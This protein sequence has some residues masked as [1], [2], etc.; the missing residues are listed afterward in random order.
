MPNTIYFENQKIDKI[1]R[2]GFYY[3]LAFI[4]IILW[5]CFIPT[6]NFFIKDVMGA[7]NYQE[8]VHLV[9]LLLG[10]YVCF[11]FT[12]TINSVFIAN[13]R[14]ELF[15]LETLVVKLTVYPIYFILY[16]LNIWIPTLDSIS[17]MFGIGLVV[18]FVFSSVIGIIV[19]QYNDPFKRLTRHIK[20]KILKNK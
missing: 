13:G 6:Y 5:L 17:I 4:V 10:F 16:K 11:V 19:L 20:Q 14:L 2:Y 7:K 3:L 12:S 15:L 8:V 9:M 1:Y 18:G